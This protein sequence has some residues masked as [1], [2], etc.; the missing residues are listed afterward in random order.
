MRKSADN[1]KAEIVAA[2]LRLAAKV[3][4]DRLTTEQLANA[5]GLTQPAIFRH[6]P[7][8]QDIWQAVAARIGAD[9]EQCW[10]MADDGGGTPSDRLRILVEAQLRLIQS[11]PALPAILFSRELHAENEG[12][13]QTFLALMTRFHEVLRLTIVEGGRIGEFRDDVDAADAAWLVL[14]LIQGLAI[15][16]SLS[17]RAFSLVDQGRRL[18]ELQLCAIIT[19][20]DERSHT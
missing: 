10:T 8:K 17:A 20:H 11:A 12:L 9:M 14:G 13:R 2:A 3:G 18:L 1:R 7:K 5:V 4:P 6:F 16:W 15:R 19:R